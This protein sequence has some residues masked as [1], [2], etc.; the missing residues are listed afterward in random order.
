MR[1][2]FT[3]HSLHLVSVDPPLL[4]FIFVNLAIF[5]FLIS[6]LIKTTTMHF[7]FTLMGFMLVASSR[8]GE[9]SVISNLCSLLA[10]Q[11]LPRTVFVSALT[12]GSSREMFSLH[13]YT[14]TSKRFFPDL[15]ISIKFFF[16]FKCACPHYVMISFFRLCSSPRRCFSIILHC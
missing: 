14:L 5:L 3:S 15:H 2:A 6:S 7:Y 8:W 11:N 12:N 4:S 10:A 16:C 13:A 9:D 1:C